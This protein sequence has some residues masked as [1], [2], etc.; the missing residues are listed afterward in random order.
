MSRLHPDIE[1]LIDRA[2]TEDGAFSDVTTSALIDPK[3]CGRAD[4]VFRQPGVCS[5]LSIAEAVF[6]RLDPE[7]RFE[8]L[9]GEGQ[10]LEAG[11]RPARIKGYL[12]AMLSGERVALNL[13]QRASGVATLTARFVK[14]VEGTGVS[15]VDTRKT[16]PGLRLLDRAAVRAGGG[17]NH[18]F[19][20]S[21]GFLA[22]DNHL[23]A[24]SA[25]GGDLTEAL[26]AAKRKVP[27]TIRM[28]VEI[29]R[30][31]QIEPALLGGADA[32]LLDNMELETLREAVRL[33]NGRA[34]IEASGGVTLDT[35]RAVALTGVDLISIGALTHSASAL[36]IS[37]EFEA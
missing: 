13:L 3:A 23:A 26:Q 24:L 30:I 22:K 34:L 35:V 6:A 18:R 20:L 27:H 12:A 4:I 10:R 16:L 14:L 31:D 28:E 15:I 25:D 8:S 17:Q 7:V 1:T 32:L 21:D 29:D 2:L 5:G 36:D 11:D 37:L 33:V 9:A 19:S